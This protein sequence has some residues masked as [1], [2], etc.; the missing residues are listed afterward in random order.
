MTELSSFLA[1]KPQL[2]HSS[3]ITPLL[4]SPP[5]VTPCTSS[6]AGALQQTSCFPLYPLMIIL[7]KAHEG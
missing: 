7:E 5:L 2:N 4:V 1:Q 3:L 6:A